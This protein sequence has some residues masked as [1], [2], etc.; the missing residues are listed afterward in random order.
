M[1]RAALFASNFQSKGSEQRVVDEEWSNGIVNDVSSLLSALREK[2]KTLPEE[3]RKRYIDMETAAT[4]HKEIIS[5]DA[6]DC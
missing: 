6:M 4:E 1:P 3:D 2:W 5:G